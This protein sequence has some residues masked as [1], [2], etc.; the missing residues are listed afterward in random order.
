LDTQVYITLICNTLV[1]E[2][3]HSRQNSHLVLLFSPL[4]L[5]LV[6]LVRHTRPKLWGTAFCNILPLITLNRHTNRTTTPPILPTAQHLHPVSIHLVVC[7]SDANRLTR[8][9]LISAY[10]NRWP[11]RTIPRVCYQHVYG[12]CRIRVILWSLRK[13]QMVARLGLDG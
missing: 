3:L 1:Q 4:L 9:F 2:A 8:A 7:D 5:C 12:R 13:H 6:H 11:E 10:T